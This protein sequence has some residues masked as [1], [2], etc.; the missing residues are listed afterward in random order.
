MPVQLSGARCSALFSV[1]DSL[2]GWFMSQ[3]ALP[4]NRL[5]HP[6]RPSLEYLNKSSNH[7]LQWGNSTL[8][9]WHSLHFSSLSS[10][11][12]MYTCWERPCTTATYMRVFSLQALSYYSLMA[13]GSSRKCVN[14]SVTQS[15][16][17]LAL[18]NKWTESHNYTVQ[19]RS[20]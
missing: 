13:I 20:P 11:Y 7:F 10:T 16:K 3:W 5:S 15:R 14:F 12:T 18:W 6:D 17:C 19:G 1:F 8:H 9:S 4:N 2:I